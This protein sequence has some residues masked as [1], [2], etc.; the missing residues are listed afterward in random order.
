MSVVLCIGG[1][2]PSGRAGLI[3]DIRAAEAQGARA[4]AVATALTI[5]SSTRA[6]GFE[7]VDPSVVRRQLEL[8]LADEPVRVAKIGQL[9]NPKTAAVALELLAD[10]PFVLDTPLSTSTGMPLFEA[11]DVG[12]AYLPLVRRAALVTPNAEEVE[13]LGGLEAL[14]AGARAILLKG[15]HRP[16]AEVVDILATADG[17]RRFFSASRIAGR[18]RGTGCRLASAIAARLALGESLETAVRRARAWLRRELEQEARAG[19]GR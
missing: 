4:L 19:D 13:R 16:G 8:L 7:P 15:G 2:D 17:T 1:L 18:F 12:E 6:G 5:Q 11:P 3:A 9:A 10:L 14:M